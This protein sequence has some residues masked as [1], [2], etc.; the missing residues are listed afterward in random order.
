MVKA[1]KHPGFGKSIRNYRTSR[2]WTQ[3]DLAIRLGVSVITIA[4]L[5]AGK[6]CTDLTR[7]KIENGMKRLDLL[8]QQAQAVA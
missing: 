1:K 6:G 4:R 8:S 3:V 5:E 7:A 2:G